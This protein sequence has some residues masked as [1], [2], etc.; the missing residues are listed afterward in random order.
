MHFSK[1]VL[2]FVAILSSFI[3]GM[4]A[5]IASS[6]VVLQGNASPFGRRYFAGFSSSVTERVTAFQYDANKEKQILAQVRKL[7][8]DLI[9]TIGEIPV[10]QLVALF[11]ST[12]IIV[13]DYFASNVAKRANVI[14][15]EN[16]LPVGYGLNMVASLFPARK[17]IGTLYNPKHSQNVLDA[18]NAAAQKLGAT[19][20]P[21]KVETPGDVA[22]FMPA[23]GGGKIDLFCFIRDATTTNESSVR[24]I[25]SFANKNNIPVLSLDPSHTEQGALL[26]I[27][28][29]PIELGEQAW[30]VAK[31]I[32]KEGKIPLMPVGTA[33]GELNV[34]MSFK[35]ATKYGIT[36]DVLYTF[37]Q[38]NLKEGF[39]IRMEP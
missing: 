6:V 3:V 29:D 16:E 2:P 32:L 31:I 19:V 24:Q 10:A 23:F 37:L 9:L 11:P 17:T 14:M 30:N 26:T 33:A 25:Y 13:A 39:T 5:A 38:K 35:S 15:M 1:A 7:T 22:S 27:S 28:L 18:L 21:L 34:S 20:V 12:P 8:P 36:A 4:S